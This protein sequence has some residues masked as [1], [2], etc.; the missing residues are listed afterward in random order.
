MK[1]LLLTI[2]CL[3]ICTLAY[4]QDND[5]KKLSVSMDLVSLMK[6]RSAKFG[7]SHPFKAKWS[8]EGSMC[9][10]IPEKGDRHP[11][12]TE[13]DSVLSSGPVHPETSGGHTL[14][15]YCIGVSYWTNNVYDGPYISLICS[16]M[17]GNGASMVLKAGYNILIW[18]GIGMNI[19]CQTHVFSLRNEDIEKKYGI[20][21]E[22]TYTF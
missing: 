17:T 7:F 12:S 4:S 11:E 6:H 15:E 13:H 8:A 22:L 2:S 14:P 20:I 10:S 19:G 16:A 1:G 3:C 9:M 21:I 5:V 18:K